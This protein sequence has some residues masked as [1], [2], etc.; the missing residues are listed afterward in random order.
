MHRHVVSRSKLCLHQKTAIVSIFNRNNQLT[1][2]C[3]NMI[4]MH[5]LNC[6]CNTA[7]AI[8]D[9]CNNAVMIFLV[10][11]FPRTTKP[12][13]SKR[14][15]FR[16]SAFQRKKMLLNTNTFPNYNNELILISNVVLLYGCCQTPCA[17]PMSIG[18]QLM[19]RR[20]KCRQICPIHLVVCCV[21]GR[22]LP[23]P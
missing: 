18:R 3:E 12:A 2:K 9:K 10:F 1:K 7:E 5:P 19:N 11:I 20:L 6:E 23:C 17:V 13:K 4:S 21:V 8:L 14:C 15:R 22:L 16:N